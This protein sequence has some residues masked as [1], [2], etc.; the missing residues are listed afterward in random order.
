MTYAI[1][2]TYEGEEQDL[3]RQDKWEK[4]RRNQRNRQSDYRDPDFIDWDEEEECQ[5]D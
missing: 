3:R 4:K 5:D 2:E 1:I